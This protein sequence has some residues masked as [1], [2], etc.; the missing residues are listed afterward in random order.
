MFGDG[1]ARRD[2]TFVDDVVD[3]TIRAG[4]TELSP[5]LVMNV[6]GSETFSVAEIL[7]S[8]GDIVGRAVPIEQK[9]AVSG[10]VTRTGGDARLARDLL[11]WR[12]QVSMSEGL[13]RQV[14][15]QRQEKTE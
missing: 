14:D 2:F 4:M 9:G 13:R 10:D 3:A 5:G 15:A 6:A 8:I 7:D 11:G 1:G 12:P